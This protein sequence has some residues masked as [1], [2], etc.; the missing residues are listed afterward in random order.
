MHCCR[1]WCDPIPSL[2]PISHLLHILDGSNLHLNT[3]APC[4]LQ[5]IIDAQDVIQ[6]YKCPNPLCGKEYDSM[7]VFELQHNAGSAVGTVQ[8]L[9]MVCDT[10]VQQVI[11]EGHGDKS[12][13]GTEHDRRQ[14]IKVRRCCPF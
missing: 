9:C 6:N 14:A 3:A 7:Q 4:L 1:Y 8:L 2:N 12:K 11:S 5:K 10:E 13:L